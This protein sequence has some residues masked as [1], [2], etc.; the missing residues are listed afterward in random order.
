[1]K[2]KLCILVLALS[3]VMC[4]GSVFATLSPV[5]TGAKYVFVFIG[6]GMGVAQR[7]AAELYLADQKGVS[8]PEEA[9]LLMNTFPAQG[10]NTTYD[11]S[12]II[13][14]SASTAT[15][16][17]TGSKTKS[18]VIGMDADTKISYETIAEKAKKKGWKVGIVSSV[19]LDHATPA[20]FYAHVPSRKQMY[21]ICMQLANSGFD[22]FAG[23][24]LLS[25]KD[26][27]DDS[28]PDAIETAKTKGYTVTTDRAGFDS[29]KKESGK[30]IAM[31]PLVDQDKAMYYAMDQADSR[32]HISLSEFVAK[33]IDLLENPNGFFMMVEGGKIDWACHAND[34][35]ASIHD[36]LAF[37]A[38][39]AEA[40]K[41]YEK[42]PQETLIVV[43][44]DHETG[45][46]TIGFAG[47]QYSAFVDKIKYQK[48]SYIEF[49]NRL[50]EYKKAHASDARFEDVLPLIKDA[51][52][53]YVL[54]AEEKAGLEKTLAEGK[55]EGA[56]DEAKKAA[57]NAEKILK[58]SMALTD[59]EVQVLR[60]AFQQ[61]MIG[62]KE[63]TTDDQTYLLYGGYDPL[64][65]KLTT[66]LNNKSG[67]AW[68][69]YSHTGV[70]VQTSAIG[71][72]SE[73]FNG[74][75]DQTD[76]YSKMM[77]ISGLSG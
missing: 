66:I 12:S 25:P 47:T 30:V 42:H 63:R 24:Q 60:D 48:M 56:S 75:Y 77:K 9:K 13:P 19:S 72:G 74:Y 39:V 49:G 70:P 18:G 64:S 68:T 17:A 52:G 50:E 8:R 35:A 55:A 67:I 2:K 21:D 15:A 73:T 27:K 10:M 53:L 46:M 61:S 59:M 45:G 62:E 6:D 29:L 76:I 54:S 4:A 71:V 31:N 44:G 26:K 33:G 36:T 40:F 43:T 11:L 23:G 32:E 34:A 41:F 65:V 69:S 22:Y 20:A 7:N 57:N 51:F 58:Y 38:A 16:I 3:L 14:D 1:M 28:K 5:Q 37:D